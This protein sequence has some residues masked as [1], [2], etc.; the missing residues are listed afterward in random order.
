MYFGMSGVFDLGI[1][2]VY[3]ECQY[4]CLPLG[5]TCFDLSLNNP[6]EWTDKCVLGTGLNLK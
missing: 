5:T 1:I 6:L 3:L 4:H 2:C